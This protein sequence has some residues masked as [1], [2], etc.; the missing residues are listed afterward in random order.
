MRMRPDFVSNFHQRL[1]GNQEYAALSAE[2]DSARE[3]SGKLKESRDTALENLRS[4][5]SNQ[6]A[7][8]FMA[9]EAEIEL[10]KI[11][12][13]IQLITSGIEERKNRIAT[14][15]EQ[16]VAEYFAND[17]SGEVFG[18]CEKAINAYLDLAE[19]D[20]ANIEMRAGLQDAGVNLSSVYSLHSGIVHPVGSPQYV[21]G[22]MRMCVSGTGYKPSKEQLNRL[23]GVL[24]AVGDS[25][26]VSM[27]DL[28][29]ELVSRNQSF[30]S[31]VAAARR[32]NDQA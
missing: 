18:L 26:G 17:L 27:P 6:A 23:A 3:E 13:S 2:I 8:A 19:V 28:N 20:V 25:S 15:R 24:H 31:A 16:V 32:A 14:I 10:L 4:A 21:L 22:F 5:R 12:H 29:P 11:E 1:S 30:Q 9:K 7:P